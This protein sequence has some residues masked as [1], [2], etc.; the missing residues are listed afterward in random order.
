MAVGSARVLQ[1]YWNMYWNKSG[2]TGILPAEIGE[3][4]GLA[5]LWLSNNEIGNLPAEIGKLSYLVRLNLDSNRIS[6][7]SQ[8]QQ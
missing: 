8:P 5:D 7:G 4:N 6:Q 2:R 1:V 3:L